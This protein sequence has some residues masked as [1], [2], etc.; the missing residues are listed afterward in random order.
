M[1]FSYF[2]DMFVFVLIK[3]VIIDVS[4]VK[5]HTKIMKNII[6]ATEIQNSIRKIKENTRKYTKIIRTNKKIY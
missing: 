6:K 5:K 3:Y 1:I 2:P 4:D